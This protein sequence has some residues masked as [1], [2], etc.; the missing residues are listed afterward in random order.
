MFYTY[1][2]KNHLLILDKDIK[3]LTRMYKANAVARFSKGIEPAS[4]R[5]INE[6]KSLKVHARSVLHRGYIR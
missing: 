1:S 3:E 6:V 4:N 2:D 5:K